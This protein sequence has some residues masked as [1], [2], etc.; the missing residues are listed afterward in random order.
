MRRV[1]VGTS[2]Q[3][4]ADV[5]RLL[6][7]VLKPAPQNGP[8]ACPDAG[9]LAAFMESGLTAAEQSAVETHLAGCGRCQEALSIL[10]HD[11]P[12]AAAAETAA[13]ET[14]WFTWVARPR[15][16]WL[17]PISAAATVAAV[18]FATRPLI[19]PEGEL[20]PASEVTR[21]AQAPAPPAESPRAAV[22]PSPAKSAAISGKSEFAGPPERQET[23]MALAETPPSPKVASD[24]LA[25]MPMAGERARDKKR[26]EPAAELITARVASERKRTPPAAPAAAPPPAGEQLAAA[27]PA[28]SVLVAADEAR[29]QAGGEA[30]RTAPAAT[31]RDARNLE[32]GLTTVSA[33]GGTVRWRFGAGGRVWRSG[34]AGDS[35]RAQPSSV[36]ADLLAG[37]APSP[38]TCWIVGTAGTVLLTTDGERWERRPFPLAVDLATVEASSARAATVTTRDGR[39][40]DTLDGGLTWS[41]R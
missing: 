13:P 1:R 11:L 38:V 5:D 6:R 32:A 39:R 16:R 12:E 20:V 37:A 26:V 10:S 22:E 40:F 34:D 29:K 31:R 25:E 4:D 14:R 2:Q 21:M 36:T 33:P 27:Q 8:G 7:A 3:R 9:V 23:A 24:A 15:L 41:P 17:V 19:A 28:R 35:W 30:D 18:F